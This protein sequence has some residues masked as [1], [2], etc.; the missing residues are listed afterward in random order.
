MDTPQEEG[1]GCTVGAEHGSQYAVETYGTILV[2]A[3]G[4]K[5]ACV[6]TSSGVWTF[7]TTECSAVVVPS[8]LRGILEPAATDANAGRKMEGL[9]LVRVW[10]GNE[11]RKSAMIRR[12]PAGRET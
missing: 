7:V 4:F 2:P 12:L 6:S 11:A 8:S 5:N 3:G 10:L 9:K 1:I